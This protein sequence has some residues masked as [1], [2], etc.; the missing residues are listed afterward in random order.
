MAKSGCPWH[1]TKHNTAE[2][3][4][5][6]P[7]LFILVCS[8][9]SYNVAFYM[10]VCQKMTL[11]EENKFSI[12]RNYVFDST[13]LY[14]MRRLDISEAYWRQNIKDGNMIE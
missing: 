7:R 1:E 12:F 5:G 3:C 2:T 9:A 13:P 6:H 11:L 4:I 14:S 8:L 10:I